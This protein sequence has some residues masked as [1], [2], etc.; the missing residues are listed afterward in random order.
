MSA[1]AWPVG[2]FMFEP[3]M[4][5]LRAGLEAYAR[6]NVRFAH[7]IL[8]RDQIAEKAATLRPGDALVWLGFHGLEHVPWGALIRRGVR[9]VYY[10][11]EPIQRCRYARL[12]IA[13]QWHYSWRNLDICRQ[14]GPGSGMTHRYVPPGALRTPTVSH[15]AKS[16]ALTFLGNSRLSLGLRGP[17][18]KHLRL[19]CLRRIRARLPGRVVDVQGLWNESAFAR[20]LLEGQHSIFVNVHKACGVSNQPL[21][22]FRI[23]K[24]LNY[25]ALV[26]SERGYARDEAEYAQLVD[27]T[28]PADIPERFLRYAA[29]GP[30]ERAALAEGRAGDFARRFEPVAL[31]AGAGVYEMLD[32]H[33]AR[34]LQPGKARNATAPA[35]PAAEGA[36]AGTS[37][38]PALQTAEV[39]R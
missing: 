3:A 2:P 26:V 7:A 31:L 29:M 11:T 38:V 1:G 35:K 6:P 21:E 34:P 32:E 27:F 37:E 23:S 39:L 33:F 9:T 24:L 16:P 10:E 12:G 4:S 18:W 5:T 15:A 17:A 19:K 8:S 13:E 36:A 22:A 25:G 20:H 30:T 14:S 28:D